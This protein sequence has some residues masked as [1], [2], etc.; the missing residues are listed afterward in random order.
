MERERKLRRPFVSLHSCQPF[1]SPYTRA[2]ANTHPT[3]PLRPFRTL[4]SPTHTLSRRGPAS[5]RRCRQVA[6]LL[7]WQVGVARL[8]AGVTQGRSVV[9]GCASPSPS[10]SPFSPPPNRIVLWRAHSDAVI[11]SA[12]SA[13]PF[14]VKVSA[15][16]PS[17]PPIR[18]WNGNHTPH[19]FYRDISSTR[20]SLYFTPLSLRNPNFSD[21][22]SSCPP[23]MSPHSVPIVSNSELRR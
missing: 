14:R 11:A 18:R 20:E 8:E 16:S 22:L 7:D 15:L 10:P 5:Q 21:G 23:R 3:T 9:S 12:Y 19:L 1:P 4:L 17:A 2:S 6:R 13:S